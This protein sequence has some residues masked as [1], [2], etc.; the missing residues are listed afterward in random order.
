MMFDL[1]WRG[2]RKVVVGEEVEGIRRVDVLGT[3][4]NRTGHPRRQD[5]SVRYHYPGKSD[6][7]CRGAENN[8]EQRRTRKK[9][10]LSKRQ[11]EGK[12]GKR[13]SRYW[14]CLE[15]LKAVIY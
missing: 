14:G 12:T 2:E 15:L 7:R 10:P 3:K 6:T 9:I 11:W 5:R 1:W 8:R 13:P 4:K